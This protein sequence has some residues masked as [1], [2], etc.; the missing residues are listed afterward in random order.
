MARPRKRGLETVQSGAEKRSKTEEVPVAG[1]LRESEQV[2][3]SDQQ[4][5]QLCHGDQLEKV[6][7]CLTLGVSVNAVSEGLRVACEVGK[8]A[9][10][11]L[12]G[13]TEGL[14]VNCPDQRGWTAAH[15]A[16][17]RGHTECLRILEQMEAVDWRR[18]NSDGLSPLN[19]LI[20]RT[21]SGAAGIKTEIK[22][23]STKEKSDGEY[24][25]EDKSFKVE[26][27]DVPERR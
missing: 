26:T 2:M 17:Y 19:F 12:L 22:T 27:L 3:I 9:V 21:D 14:E 10:V 5:V 16:S 13:R 20:S 15:H 4:F 25:E 24:F 1:E 23:E 8:P 18:R 6:S 11:S 7:A